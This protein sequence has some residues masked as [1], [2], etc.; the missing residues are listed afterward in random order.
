MTLSAPSG[1]LRVTKVS[2]AT[3]LKLIAP[4]IFAKRLGASERCDVRSADGDSSYDVNSGE[5]SDSDSEGTEER[6][7]TSYDGAINQPSSSSS[8][9]SNNTSPTKVQIDS[10]YALRASITCIVPPQ[11]P[12]H[13]ETN[14]SNAKHTAPT[15]SS[16]KASALVMVDALHGHLEVLIDGNDNDNDN[17]D[18]IDEAKETSPPDTASSPPLLALVVERISGSV[19]ARVRQCVGGV[20][21]HFD[22]PEGEWRGWWCCFIIR[23]RLMLSC[24]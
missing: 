23:A 22:Q 17:S 6:Q 14:K 3:R 2:E 11:W 4:N 5:G 1:T 7:Q 18:K 15:E 13:K 16:K 19:S 10:L 8:S 21:A 20:R 9:S 12:H 24:L